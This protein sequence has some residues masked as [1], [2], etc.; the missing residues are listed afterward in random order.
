M[1]RLPFPVILWIATLSPAFSSPPADNQLESETWR[2]AF[3]FETIKLKGNYASCERV[4]LEAVPVV[5]VQKGSPME[6]EFYFVNRSSEPVGYWEPCRYAGNSSRMHLELERCA[7]G[8]QVPRLESGCL[9]LLK[10]SVHSLENNEAALCRI[11]LA[12]KFGID[13]R[14]GNLPA[15]LY[16]LRFVSSLKEGDQ[17]VELGCPP[18]ETNQTILL[19]QIEDASP[20]SLVSEPEPPP[21]TPTPTIEDGLEPAAHGSTSRR[22]WVV[23]ASV[24]VGTLGLGAVVGFVVGRRSS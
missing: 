20:E 23:F 18:M 11:S 2:P 9:A 5:R 21:C 1:I 16:A 19:I 14:R 22:S 6:I 24:A 10:S 4:P 15:G 12:D 17:L 13:Y 7:T 8:E 3:R